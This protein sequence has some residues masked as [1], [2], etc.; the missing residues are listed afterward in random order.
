M[1]YLIYTRG[2]TLLKEQHNHLFTDYGIGRTLLFPLSLSLCC[3]LY[4][5]IFCRHYCWY[6]WFSYSFCVIYLSPRKKII[7]KLCARSLDNTEIGNL[8]LFQFILSKCKIRFDY[9][10]WN[11]AC[12]RKIEISE[13][14]KIITKNLFIIVP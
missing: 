2:L 3:L 1:V 13:G 5:M 8:N 4:F 7:G 6:S 11:F 10:A 9:F 14:G 12:I